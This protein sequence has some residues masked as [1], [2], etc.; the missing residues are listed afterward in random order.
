MAVLFALV[1]EVV[2]SLKSGYLFSLGFYCRHYH[3]SAVHVTRT[4]FGLISSQCIMM[5]MMMMMMTMILY[6]YV[7]FNSYVTSASRE[8]VFSKLVVQSHFLIVTLTVLIA[9]TSYYALW[10]ARQ[11]RLQSVVKNY[12]FPRHTKSKRV[13]ETAHAPTAAILDHVVKETENKS[14]PS[15]QEPEPEPERRSTD[16]D[17]AWASATTSPRTQ[18]PMTSSTE[19]GNSVTS[20]VNSQD[21]RLAGSIERG[22]GQSL[23]T[24]F[25]DYRSVNTADSFRETGFDTCA[26]T[27][28][29][30]NGDSVTSFTALERPGSTDR[31][32]AESSDTSSADN[33]RTF[34]SVD[35]R[36]SQETNDRSKLAGNDDTGVGE[37]RMTSLAEVGNPMTPFTNDGH[38]LD[39]RLAGSNACAAKESSL[40]SSTN[41]RNSV[42]SYSTAVIVPTSDERQALGADQ[43]TGS[44]YLETG[45]DVVKL[46]LAAQN[47]DRPMIL[48]R[49]QIPTVAEVLAEVG[50]AEQSSIESADSAATTSDYSME[51]LH[52]SMLDTSS[53]RDLVNISGEQNDQ[54]GA[55]QN[56][57]SEPAQNTTTSENDSSLERGDVKFSL[58]SDTES[59][60][61]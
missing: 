9:G 39:T 40:T 37:S 12:V 59:I 14:G 16:D 45:S 41:D 28:I 48:H 34:R 36:V 3:F 24:S 20:F 27:K 53:S 52:D 43:S 26:T 38:F 61:P 23:M 11:Q 47:E 1:F 21:A 44:S 8:T 30:D 25:A 46:V 6:M 18:F 35:D 55:A 33:V 54:I 31:A 19:D 5:M 7:G 29:Q 51:L 49:I 58:Q 50:V 15:A 22:D 2:L 4:Y 56:T 60:Y 42:T 17:D 10:K 57:I 13:A 32:P